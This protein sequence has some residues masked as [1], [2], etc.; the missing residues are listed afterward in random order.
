MANKEDE[1]LIDVG[2]VYSQS[3]Q[4]VEKNK[5]ALTIA[6]AVLITVVGAYF[7]YTAYLDGQNT[8][9][10]DSIWKAEYYL[11]VDSLDKAIQGDGQYFGFEYIAE[12]YSGT[13][14]GK[15]ANY[16]LGIIYKEKGDYDLA[17]EYLKSANVE[18]EVLGAISLGNLGDIYV[19]LGE[20]QEALKY[21]NKAISHSDNSFTAPIYLNKAA[22]TYS[23]LENYNKATDYYQQIVDDYPNSPEA[24]E[25]KKNLARV[26]QLAG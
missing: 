17:I 23:V 16:Y 10:A 14:T 13:K 21:F 18:D 11:E 4:F 3:E 15:L 9:A 20:Y 6:V 24:R 26:K 8:E 25:V 5:K 1:N 12:N 7:G 2:K 22:I 19:D